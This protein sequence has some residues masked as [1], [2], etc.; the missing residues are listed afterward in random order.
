MDQGRQYWENKVPR[1]D[2]MDMFDKL[3]G[4]AEEAI[5]K[6]NFTV[7]FLVKDIAL[8]PVWA[9]RRLAVIYPHYI[10]TFILTVQLDLNGSYDERIKEIRRKYNLDDYLFYGSRNHGNIRGYYAFSLGIGDV[11]DEKKEAFIELFKMSYEFLKPYK[12]MGVE[13]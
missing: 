4:Y 5:G 10:E 2:R 3:C 11:T 7:S 9:N 6:S 1:S 8:K 12:P 13:I